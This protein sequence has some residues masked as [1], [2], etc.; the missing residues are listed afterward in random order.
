MS[1]TPRS[2]LPKGFACTK[3]DLFHLFTSYVYAHYDEALIHTCECGA[4]HEIV[5]GR[6][7][8]IN[9]KKPKPAR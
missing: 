5:R 2:K 7:H 6:P 3:C 4:K 9:A 1:E 8:A